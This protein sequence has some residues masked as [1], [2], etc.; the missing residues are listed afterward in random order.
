MIGERGDPA[1]LGPD[2]PLLGV[3]HHA[4]PLRHLW[5]VPGHHDIINLSRGMTPR[6]L[7]GVVSPARV[8]VGCHKLLRDM[9]G[10]LDRTAL[11]WTGG[12]VSGRHR[13]VRVD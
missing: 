3:R 11:G 8:T 7:V 9:V 12:K 2:G 4:K 10:I 1:V 13:A 5:G 6:G